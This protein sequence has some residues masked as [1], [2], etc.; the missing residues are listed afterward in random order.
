[1][2]IGVHDTLEFDA[3]QN[4]K[5]LSNFRLFAHLDLV[6]SKWKSYAATPFTVMYR[7]A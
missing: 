3:F 2:T 4:Y 1:M 7:N 6:P 5:M